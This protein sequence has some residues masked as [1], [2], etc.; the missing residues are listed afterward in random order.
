M[1]GP[2]LLDSSLPWAEFL[3][4]IA[5]ELEVAN[6][7]LVV[8]NLK[9]KLQKPANSPILGLSPKSGYPSMMRRIHERPEKVP[10]VTIFMDSPLKQSQT[11][12]SLVSFVFSIICCI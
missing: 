6:D 12:K 10:V 7:R 2:I 1:A 11:S 8:G 4:Q 5:T 9:W 3:E